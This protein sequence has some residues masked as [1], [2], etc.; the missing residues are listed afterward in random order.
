MYKYVVLVLLLLPSLGQGQ[1]VTGDWKGELEVNGTKLPIIFHLQSDSSGEVTGNWDSP[2]QNA[3][4]L[5]FSSISVTEDSLVAEIENIG[6]AYKGKFANPDSLE[7]TWYQG[8]GS[9]PLNFKKGPPSEKPKPYPGAQDLKLTMKDGFPVYGTLV[10]KNAEETLVIIIAG[11]GPTDRNGNSAVGL[12]T[13][14]YQLLARALD[15]QHISTFRYDK[16]GVGESIQPGMKEGDL[17]IEDYVSDVVDMVHYFREKEGFQKIYIAGHSEGSLIGMLAVEQVHP[18]GF[19]SI[20][21]A[22]RPIDVILKE[23]LAKQHMPDSLVTE[24]DGILQVLKQG[25]T[26]KNVSK[27]LQGLFRESVQPYIASW[28]KYN[29]AKEIKKLKIPVLIVQGSCDIQVSL[30]DAENLHRAAPKSIEQVIKGMTHVLKYAGENCE[31][32]QSTYTD[33]QLPIDTKL[34]KAITYFIQ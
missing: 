15:S 6:G 13:D 11:S 14:A 3:I 33:S 4:G 16:R 12:R 20:A 24:V 21:G 30:V 26:V 1:N 31:A 22:G 9:L 17:S 29:P 28:M 34:V 5:P 2:A 25:K 32:E 19:I 7:G 27:P 18:A 23:Q 10:S 8:M